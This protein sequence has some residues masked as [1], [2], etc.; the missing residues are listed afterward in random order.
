[1]GFIRDRVDLASVRLDQGR[2]AQAGGPR[3]IAKEPGRPRGSDRFPSAR[4]V[5]RKATAKR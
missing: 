4:S 3:Q 1:M 5:K 2:A